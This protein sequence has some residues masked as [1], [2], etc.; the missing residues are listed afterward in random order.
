MVWQIH[1]ARPDDVEGVADALAQVIWEAHKTL[2]KTPHLWLL[3]SLCAEW[4]I[5]FSWDEAA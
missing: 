5:E 1:P 4:G 3:P 2:S